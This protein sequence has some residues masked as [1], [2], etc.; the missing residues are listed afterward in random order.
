[1]DSKILNARKKEILAQQETMLA[2]ATEAKAPLTDT[3]EATYS[4]LT[5]E[6]DSINVNI[7]RFDAIA[8]G[9]CEVGVP[10]QE[11]LVPANKGTSKFYA[12]GASRIKTEVT[13]EYAE[14]FWNQFSD[15]NGH[16]HNLRT[17][18]F[19]MA[20]LGEGGTAADGSYL[21]PSQTDP[22][23]P[24]LAIIEASA[25]K[26]SR[27]ITTEMDLKL[28]YQSAK[29][30]A[31][32]KSE[33][34]NSGTNAFATNVPQFN[35]TTLTAYM[36]GDSIYVSWELMQDV[37]ALA[38]FVTAELNRAVFVYE[39][40]AFIN[41]NGSGAPL[42][43]LNGATTFATEALNIGNILDLVAALNKQYYAGASFLFNRAEFHR[44]Y[45][46]QIAASQY[47]TWVTYDANGQARLLGFPVEFSSVMPTYVASPATNGAVLFGDFSAGW[48]IGDRG[49]SNIRVKVLDQP[50]AVNGQ[51]IV[52][53]YRRTDQRCILQEAVQLLTT[54]S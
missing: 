38:Q 3:E 22:S 42:G 14:A 40:N 25:R 31:A 16:G 46:T 2:K 48:V 8:K 21:V 12:L 34:N 4:N 23:I 19:D 29:A 33:S 43:Y 44:L 53:G 26:L 1:M 36:G 20:A 28:P 13:S 39:E 10:Q 9:R 41:G 37:K 5:K 6:L 17:G 45:K 15:K 7:A 54:S 11:V 50:A 51:T 52:L 32:Q 49:D 27:V 47:Q 35:T 18:K 24:N 30:T